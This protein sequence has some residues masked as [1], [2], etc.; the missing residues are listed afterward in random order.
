[1]SA[2]TRK[3]PAVAADTSLTA[4]ENLIKAHA[5][6]AQNSTAKWEV[7]ADISDAIKDK[8]PIVRVQAGRLLRMGRDENGNDLY[9][10]IYK[11][12]DE[13]IEKFI[14]KNT[15]A[16]LAMWG[17]GAGGDERRQKILRQHEASV[18][19]KKDELAKVQAERDRIE[20]ESGYA[21]ALAAAKE[22]ASV[23]Y[24]LE[25]QITSFVP[26]TLAAAARLAA[27]I[28]EGLNEQFPN[29][30]DEDD[31]IAALSAIAAAGPKGGA[32]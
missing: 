18:Q 29:S 21:A 25:K 9:D 28:V 4:L 20:Q 24:G 1:M 17:N 2:A 3:T 32:A 27:W 14:Q 31:A 6:A 26:E 19:R 22:A 10:P 15:D 16:M 23:T 12:D 7:E 8:R 11:Y 5:E 13:G 30:L